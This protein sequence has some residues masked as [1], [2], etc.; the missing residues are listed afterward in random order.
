MTPTQCPSWWRTSLIQDG[1][2]WEWF[3]EFGK[4]C[5]LES[6]LS[7]PFLNASVL[8]SIG[9]Y[10]HHQTST[11]EHRFHFGPVASFFL[12]PLIIALHSSPVA[13]WAPA[14]LGGSSSDV[15]SFCLFI[16]STGFSKQE[17]QSGLPFPPPGDDIL[18]ELFTVTHLGWPCLSWFIASLSYASPVA[19]TRLWP[20]K[21][22]LDV[23]KQEVARMNIS[24]LRISEL[25]WV[26]MGEFNSDNQYIYSC[27]QESLRGNG[28]AL[29]VNKSSKHS[30]WWNL[31]NDRMISVH[32]QGK[33]FNSTVIQICAPTIDAK[34]TAVDW[35]CENLQHP[36]ELRPKKD[37]LFIIEG[38][39][40]KEVKRYLE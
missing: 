6:P 31:K 4:T 15:I 1:V 20:I 12:E 30:P 26:R 24:F 9:L 17:Y 19:T 11:T 16:L 32:F 34:E 25:K 35:F 21:G 7:C 27:G 2:Q 29:I 33:P 39:N 14:N 38:W 36:L 23:V 5:G 22:K 10:F 8:D 13:Y 3:W 18:S 40:A 28:V 37:V